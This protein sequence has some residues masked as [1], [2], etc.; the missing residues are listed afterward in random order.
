MKTR[1]V[2]IIIF[3]SSISRFTVAQVTDIDGN[4]YK[5]IEIG[6][7]IWMAE[8]LKVTHYADGR[9]IPHVTNRQEWGKLDYKSPA[10]CFYNDS[11][12]NKN[13]FGVLYTW[14]TAMDCANSSDSSPSG[15]QGACPMGWHLPSEAEWDI[16]VNYLDGEDL[17]GSK[18]KEA[19]TGIWKSPNAGATNSNGFTALPGG[20]R[21][22]NG[23]FYG[24]GYCGVWWSTTEG[25]AS[26]AWGRYMDYEGSYVYKGNYEFGGFSIRCIK[27]YI[28][29]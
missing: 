14:A 23:T 12:P 28:G 18:L 6:N 13:I 29:N 26:S 9:A 15:V 22:R 19:G 24:I 5:T 17:A 3:I 16:L 25:S 11:T 1:D 20:G 10:Y 8:N 4:T 2:F 27:D 21:S 7:Q